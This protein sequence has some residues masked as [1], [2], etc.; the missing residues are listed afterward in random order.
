VTAL[1]AQLLERSCEG[2]TEKA[3]GTPAPNIEKMEAKIGRL[4]LVNNF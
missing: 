4:T 1:K 3:A 2:F